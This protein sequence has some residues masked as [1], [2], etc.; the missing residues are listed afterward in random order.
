MRLLTIA[1]RVLSL[2]EYGIRRQLAQ[3]PA[4]EPLRGL[5]AGQPNRSTRPA[6]R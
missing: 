5:A 4:V 1:V 6:H 2:L 3:T